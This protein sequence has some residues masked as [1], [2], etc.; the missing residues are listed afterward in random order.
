MVCRNPVKRSGSRAR[1]HHVRVLTPTQFARGS[2]RTIDPG[3]VGGTKITIAC[4]KG[5]WN[6][7]KKR[8]RVGTELQAILV[9]KGPGAKRRLK[10]AKK[11][12]V[13]KR[14]TSKRKTS[15]RRAAP[16][17]GRMAANPLLM[18]VG[19]NPPLR[20]KKLVAALQSFPEGRKALAAYRRFH[21]TDPVSLKTV[22]IKAGGKAK[23]QEFA[24]AM[25]EA[26]DVTYKTRNRK[27]SKHGTTY[28]HRYKNRPTRVFIP[29]AGA[30]M[31]LPGKW[32]VTDWVRG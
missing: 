29:S 13:K 31:D 22:K 12:A 14:R 20:G 11:E 5:Q 19:A 27:S 25:G 32:K 8:C 2:F 3:K 23:Q 15:T 30:I 10:A 6:K 9:E 18:I 7:W 17:R 4:P 26:P 24:I 21:K 28:I 1:Y 16:A